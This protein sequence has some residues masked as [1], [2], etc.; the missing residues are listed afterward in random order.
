MR[1]IRD[2]RLWV[3]VALLLPVVFLIPFLGG[4]F[5]NAGSAYTDMAISH[6]PNALWLQKS[7]LND[8]QVPLWSSTILSGFPFF[9]DP[10]SG[11]HYPFGW[12][13]ILLP[14]PFGLNLMAVLHLAFGG[15]G[16]FLFLRRDDFEPAIAIFGAV[17]YEA[18]PKL[19]A[20]L[21]AGHLTLVYAAAWAPWLLAA[22]QSAN[23]QP[24]HY[25]MLPGLVLGIIFLADPRYAALAGVVW[26]VYQIHW[27]I[28]HRELRPGRARIML[29]FQALGTVVISF[30]VG[31]FLLLPMLEYLGLST[32]SLMSAKDTLAL[33]LPPLQILGLFVPNMAGTAEWMIYPGAAVLVLAVLGFYF[34]GRKGSKLVWGIFFAATLVWSMGENIPGLALISRLPGFNLLRVPPRMLL[35]GFVG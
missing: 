6:Y 5:Y 12:P 16:M 35:A 18:M 9:A 20:H 3:G 4:F 25:W 27:L 14:L 1:V 19:F 33:S 13:A 24:R 7:L 32:R 11:L 15:L 8:G 2:R 23:R 10:L 26:A 21:G 22:Q 31:A 34:P 30:G 29:G 28:G 17:A